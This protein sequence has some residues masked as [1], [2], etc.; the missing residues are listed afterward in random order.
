M[1][2]MNVSLS[3]NKLY[4]TPEVILSAHNEYN[5]TAI[6]W[7]S[8][9]KIMKNLALEVQEECK[10]ILFLILSPGLYFLFFTLFWYTPK[11]SYKWHRLLLTVSGVRI[12]IKFSQNEVS[13][14]VV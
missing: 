10:R 8:H 2:I 1:M 6:D 3:L 4:N 13:L 14:L 9:N 5:I 11:P 12:N 7:L